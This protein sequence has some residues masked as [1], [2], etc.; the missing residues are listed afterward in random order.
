VRGI[1]DQKDSAAL[2]ADITKM[3]YQAVE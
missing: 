1:S 3:L 2:I